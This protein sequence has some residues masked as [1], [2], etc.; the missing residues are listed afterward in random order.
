[1]ASGAAND[2]IGGTTAGSG[3]VISGN[4]GGDIFGIDLVHAGTGNVVEGN[5]IGT[6][7]AGTAALGN[8]DGIFVHFSSGVTI[9]GTTAS[10]RNLISGNSQAGIRLSASSNVTIEGN[11]I[12]LN[13]AGTA[14]LANAYAGFLTDTDNPGVVIGG[15]TSTPGTGAGNVIS[16]NGYGIDPE[17][18]PLGDITV[19][20]NLIG[21]DPT[22]TFAI[23]NGTGVRITSGS[24]TVGGTAAG[25]GNVISGNTGDGVLIIDSTSTGSVI[26]GNDIGT[27]ISGTTA[28][29]NQYGI[30]IQSGA[31]GTTIGGTTIAAANLISGN[32]HYGIEATGATT[33]GNV[34]EG[35]YIGTQAGGSGTLLNTGGALE[36]TSGASVQASGSFTG[37]VLNQG[38]L[39]V[40]NSPGTIAITG[41]YTQSSGATLNLNIGGTTA[42]TGYDQ[43]TVSGT[44]TLAGTLNDSLTGGFVPDPTQSFSVLTGN[45]VSGTFGTV[46]QP[47]YTGRALLSTQYNSGSV[48]LKGTTIV[49]NS[50]ADA[51][52]QGGGSPDTGGTVNGQAQIT[53]RSAIQAANALGGTQYIYFD[54]PTS[55]AN[56]HSATSSWTIAPATVL[57][58]IST[59]TVLDATTQPGYAGSPEIELS[60]AN[61]PNSTYVNGLNVTAGSTTI[62]GFAINRFLGILSSATGGSGIALT[63]NGGD[64]IQADFLGTDVTGTIAE[65]NTYAGVYV[66]SANNTIGGTTAAARNVISGGNDRGV[67]LGGGTATLNIVEGNYIG[68]TASGLAALGNA[69]YGIRVDDAAGNTI[70]GLTSTAGTGPGNVISGNGTGTASGVSIIGSNGTGNVVEGNIIGL[71]ADGSSTM[72]SGQEVG[73]DTA[74]S[75][76]GNTIGGTAAAA[77]NIISGNAY[78][79]FFESGGN[80]ALGNYIGT[81]I[82]GALARGNTVAGVYIAPRASW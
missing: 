62:K 16:G 56:Y 74:S 1:M 54:I 58:T 76:A 68:T 45:N 14:A 70:G 17:G 9:G 12:G 43:L 26:E 72:G 27:T 44:A 82:T 22:G 59:P 81:D 66:T 60:G 40:A 39:S 4:S 52:S 51:V 13:A 63:G 15:L 3:N 55:D 48:V 47:T 7:A 31:S 8:F 41:T 28:L 57:P 32:S 79:V 19:E 5:E 11:W 67:Y 18:G 10:A 69:T 20:G 6:N 33:T 23:G 71:G 30:V 29:G 77:R 42:G 80:T 49:V 61:I 35:N 64:V 75:A 36:I 73:V 46:N 21:T 24:M 65:A 2:V 78:G 37:N 50:T 38:S 34:V 53:L 25:A